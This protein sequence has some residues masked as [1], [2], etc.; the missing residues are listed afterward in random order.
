[1]MTVPCRI[2]ELIAEPQDQDVLDHLLA[3]VVVDAEDLLLLPVGV[4]S[5]LEVPGALKILAERLLNLL[6]R[7]GLSAIVASR[8]LALVNTHNDAG[9]AALGVAVA[10]QLFR[11]GNENTRRQRHIEDTVLLLALTALLDLLEVLVEVDERLILVVLARD[12]GA[13]LAELI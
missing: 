12:V 6:R 2:E 10:L 11:H 13:Q 4:Q 5:L 8:H 3:E 1:M 7:A 9:E